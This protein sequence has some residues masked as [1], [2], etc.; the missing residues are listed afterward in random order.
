M[1]NVDEMLGLG[2]VGYTNTTK[3]R[4]HNE[5]GQKV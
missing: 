5:K 2:K 4:N 3:Y 1:G